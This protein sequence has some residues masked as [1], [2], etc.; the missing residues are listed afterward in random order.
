[1]HDPVVG[2]V[3]ETVYVSRGDVGPGKYDQYG[4]LQHQYQGEQDRSVKQYRGFKQV[5]IIICSGL[6]V[7]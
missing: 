5:G 1:M 7:C 2:D 6:G 4:V 3:Y